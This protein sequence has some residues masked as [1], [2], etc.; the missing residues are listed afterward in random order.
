MP[1]YLGWG[2]VLTFVIAWAVFGAIVGAVAGLCT[3]AVLRTGWSGFWQDAIIGG[4]AL[5]SAIVFFA[6]LPWPRNTI[7]YTLLRTKTR[8]TLR[9]GLSPIPSGERAL[10]F[11]LAPVGIFSLLVAAGVRFR[12]PD[13]E[14]TLHF[15]WLS[16]AFFGMLAFSFSGRLETLDWTIYWADVTS[17]LLLPPL[18]VHFALVFPERP[19]SWAHSDAGRT[20]LPLLYLPALL[21]FAARVS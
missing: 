16:V 12:R 17:T 8:E 11:I 9:V 7:T 5:P 4:I 1:F 15:F 2:V 18:I 14:A 3:A 19:D 13:N 20:A 10:Y 21:L 6:F